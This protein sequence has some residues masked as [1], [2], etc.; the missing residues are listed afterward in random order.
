MG[1]ICDGYDYGV[2]CK[3]RAARV[4]KWRAKYKALG[5][6]K[7]EIDRIVQKRLGRGD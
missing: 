3:L 6:S 2:R 1:A 7:T 4:A 5:L